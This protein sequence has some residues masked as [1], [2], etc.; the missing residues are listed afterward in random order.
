MGW[1]RNGATGQAWVWLTP[2]PGQGKNQ[3]WSHS[4]CY[5]PLYLNP[6]QGGKSFILGSS[7][8]DIYSMKGENTSYL[9]ILCNLEIIT[10]QINV[11]HALVPVKRKKWKLGYLEL[12]HTHNYHNLSHTHTHTQSLKSLSVRDHSGPTLITTPM[13]FLS[14]S[15]VML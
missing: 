12:P 7:N 10:K 4:S 14:A 15:Q 11:L 3:S 8:Y 1:G 9:E 5:P 2:T 6:R 13:L